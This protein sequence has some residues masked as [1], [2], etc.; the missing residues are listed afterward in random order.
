V[1]SLFR[2]YSSG[3]VAN[4]RPLVARAIIDRFSMPGGD[5]LDFCAGFGGRLLGSLTLKR[6]YIGVDASCLQ[7][8]GS[9]NMLKA[10]RRIS[11]GSAEL[12]HASAEDFLPSVPAR[13]VDLVFS[14]P[15]FF[16]TELYSEE[17]T[18]ST[19]RYPSYREWAH[20]FL[21]VVI[22]EAHRIARPGGFFVINVADSRKFQVRTDTL[23]FAIPVFGMPKTIRLV[24]HSRPLQRATGIE[25]FRWE[26]VFVFKT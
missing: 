2:T 1:R 19:Q 22:L 11:L 7:V 26:P 10:L 9:K 12:H 18:Q 4:F 16:N 13:S 21:K 3:R 6:H 15:P 24:M 25:I 17:P 23:R 5:V 20:L 14:S 8:N